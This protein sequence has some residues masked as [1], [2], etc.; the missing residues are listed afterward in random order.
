MLKFWYD[1][2][3]TCRSADSL[4]AETQT[5]NHTKR[6]PDMLKLKNADTLS[7]WAPDL[8]DSLL[9]ANILICWYTD[10]Q[11]HRHANILKRLH[12][13]ILTCWLADLLI[14]CPS[15][16]LTIWYA[17]TLTWHAEWNFYMMKHRHAGLQPC[18]HDDMQTCKDAYTLADMLKIK[19]SNTMTWW[20]SD[21]LT[22]LLADFL[23]RWY[24]DMQTNRAANTLMGLHGDRQT[25][26]YSDLQTC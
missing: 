6:F 23:I 17:D 4:Y 3:V 1:E 8:L 9:Y 19:N 25:C 12:T 2:I 13:E 18:L 21:M 15:N 5:C 7:W 22:S 20:P 24:S 14:F 11:T 16:I 10:M 26:W